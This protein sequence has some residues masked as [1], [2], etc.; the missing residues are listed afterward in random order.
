MYMTTIEKIEFLKARIGL[1]NS[2]YALGNTSLKAEIE[3]HEKELEILIA[4]YKSEERKRKI[5]EFLKDEKKV[6]FYVKSF[7]KMVLK[8]F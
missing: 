1:K 8:Q 7:F 2:Y 6:Y 4:Q 3:E 5:A